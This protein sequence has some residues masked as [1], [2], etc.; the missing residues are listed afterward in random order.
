MMSL[1]RHISPHRLIALALLVGSIGC[2]RNENNTTEEED[3][4]SE[5]VVADM[6]SE[7]T[8][9]DMK[10]D[11]TEEDMKPDEVDEDMRPDE[12]EEDMKMEA[13]EDMRPEVEEDMKMEME[14]DMKPEEPML[15]GLVVFDEAFGAGGAFVEFGGSV[16]D[17]SV[18]SNE[19]LNGMSSIKIEVPGPGAYTGGA[20]V[21]NMP[22]DVS[23]YNALVF[24][25]KAS[26]DATLNAVGIGNDA[27]D[28]ARQLEL[29]GLAL[30]TTWQEVVFPMPAPGKYNDLAGLMHFAEGGDEGPYTIWLD[31]IHYTNVDAARIGTIT[32]VMAGQMKTVEV[33][34]TVEAEGAAV[35]VEVDGATLSLAA[36]K[37]LFDWTSTDTAIA[38]VDAA[39]VVTG[40]AE[41][42]ATINGAFDGATANGQ[43]DVTVVP[44]P[45]VT[46]PTTAAPD[47]QAMGIV[48][49][50]YGRPGMDATVGTYLTGWSQ[51]AGMIMLNEI[52]VAGDKIN[53]YSDVDFFGINFETVNAI[54]L[55]AATT[56]HIDIWTPDATELLIKL[57]DFGANGEFGGDDNLEVGYTVN[58]MTTPAL[59]TGQWVSLDI[60]FANMNILAPP[61]APGGPTTGFAQRS[62]VAQLIIDPT[63][64]GTYGIFIGNIYFY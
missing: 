47:P 60:P 40:K 27:A 49:S 31:D 5:E 19:A 12:A 26:K 7:E 6:K 10:S 8:E 25:I 48:A 61:P 1:E 17:V 38:E 16:N 4:R 33:N 52:D 42:T 43:L 53:H 62:N 45:A 50:L 37:L 14:E 63:I 54:D 9:G 13:E 20:I 35:L 24:H 44:A 28:N 46:A 30:T 2:G 34:K 29:G 11:A 3:M 57:V 56:M 23:G 41:G 39:G 51:P 18:D 21:A 59:T 64:P 58:A 22:Q 32:P 55:S 36:N 15:D